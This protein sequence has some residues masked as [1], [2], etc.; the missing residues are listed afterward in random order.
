MQN[1][2]IFVNFYEI[3]VFGGVQRNYQ[4][5]KSG[6]WENTKGLWEMLKVRYLGKYKEN[7]PKMKSLYMGKHKEYFQNLQNPGMWENAKEF[8]NFVKWKFW[9]FHPNCFMT[10]ATHDCVP[11][12][13]R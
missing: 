4:I 7:F 2:K 10:H 12:P 3:Q 13:L 8:Q 1:A 6:N 9:K 11:V 5:P